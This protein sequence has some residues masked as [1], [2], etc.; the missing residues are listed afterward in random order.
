MQMGRFASLSFLSVIGVGVV[1]S[2]T[3]FL[4]NQPQ[5]I[6]QQASTT[7]AATPTVEPPGC[8]ATNPD[9]RE[10]ICRS[11]ATC[12]AGEYEKENGKEECTTRLGKLSRCCTV[13]SPN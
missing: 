11:E 12:H 2:I 3:I 7:I 4:V 5:D 13:I 6:R 8:P 10:N 1:L 9:G